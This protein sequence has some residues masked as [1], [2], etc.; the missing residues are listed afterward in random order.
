MAKVRNN[1]VTRGWSGSFGE[2]MVIKIDKAGRAI[3]GNKPEF[4]EN[5]V[6]TPAQLAH[7]QAF[8]EA[9]IYAKDAKE[10]V[11]YVAKA[12]GTPISPANAAL[13]DWF[14]APEIKVIDLS[15]WRGE[16]GQ[17][18]RIEALDDGKVTQVTVVITDEMNAVLEQGAALE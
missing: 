15:A 9:R 16:M 13:V 17:Q 12:E 8:R 11:V 3:V 18:I 10:E 6:F 14:H 1:V 5:R 2:Q 7:Q 4:D